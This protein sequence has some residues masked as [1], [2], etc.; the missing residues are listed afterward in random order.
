MA[1][2]SPAGLVGALA[3]ARTVPEALLAFHQEILETDRNASAGL[4]LYDSRRAVLRERMLASAGEIVTS[5]VSVS[6]DH[7]PAPVRKAVQEGRGFCELGAQS[8]DYMRLLGLPASPDSGL[9]LLRGLLVDGELAAVVTL[10]EP[11]RVFGPRLSERLGD[12]VEL[13][14]L[15]FLGLS[16][17]D[18][19]KEAA[20]RLEELTRELHQHHDLAL[21]TLQRRLDEALAAVSGIAPDAR[22]TA[23]QKI[24]DS[25]ANEARTTAQ[26][27]VAVEEQVSAAVTSLERAHRQL[28]EQSESA[29]QQQNLLYRIERMLRDSAEGEDSSKIIEEILAVVSSGSPPGS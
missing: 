1:Q 27:L 2:K 11:R 12:A 25:A 5:E 24:A 14:S 28:Y 26:R 16:E 18:A 20:R 17:R 4:F 19:R 8:A 22:M 15:A 7:F 21:A 9:L 23:L 3:A 29:R 10:Y 13:F 6:L